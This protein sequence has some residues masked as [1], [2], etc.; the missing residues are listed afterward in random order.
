VSAGPDHSELLEVGRIGKAHGLRGEVAVEFTTDRVTERTAAGARLWAGD[1]C[2]TVATA[3]PHQRRW[4]IRFEGIDDRTGAERLRG[5]VLRADPIDD[6]DAVFVH[7][8]VGLSVIDQH[9]TDHG[10]IVALVDNPASDLLELEGGALVPMAF[11]RGHGPDDTVLVEVP[12]GLLDGDDAAG[13][14]VESE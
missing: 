13:D 3:R 8:L 14:G 7:Q 1:D 10:P 12:P 11:Y 5:R 4:L 6:P 2:L 9:G